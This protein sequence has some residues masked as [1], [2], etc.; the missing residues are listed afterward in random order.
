MKILSITFLAL[1][2]VYVN[3]MKNYKNSNLKKK[4][5]LSK[6]EEQILDSKIEKLDDRL[7]RHFNKV[8]KTLDS[9]SD[10]LFEYFQKVANRTLTLD[11]LQCI[12]KDINQSVPEISLETT[13]RIFEAHELNPNGCLCIE[14]F[15]SFMRELHLTYELEHHL[16]SLGQNANFLQTGKQDVA[17]YVQWEV[18]FTIHFITYVRTSPKVIIIS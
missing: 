13:D 4:D 7:D 5:N 15:R 14:E 11:D 2:L 10:L 12:V 18:E 17:I 3:T 16:R 6:I 9:I 1:L 8:Y